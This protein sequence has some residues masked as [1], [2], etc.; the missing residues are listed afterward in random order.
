MVLI[1]ITESYS[2]NI[3][4]AFPNS[5]D[6]IFLLCRCLRF[7]KLNID[8]IHDSKLIDPLL[9]FQY[10]V[11]S[12]DVA[13][14]Q[15]QSKSDYLCF[16]LFVPFDDHTPEPDPWALMNVNPNVYGVVIMPNRF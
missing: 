14:F 6:Q 7:C 2:D 5:N 16:Y 3:S 13:S 8:R 15:I 11:L 12:E 9:C 10:F 4:L 1:S